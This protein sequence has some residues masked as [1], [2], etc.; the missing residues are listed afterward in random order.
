MIYLIQD[1]YKDDKGKYIDIL[2][3]GYSSKPFKESRENQ[4]KTHNYG[5]K[6]IGEREGDT[7]LEN[8]LHTK[9]KDLRLSEEWFLYS[10]DIVRE[11]FIVDEKNANVV[12][13]KE[14]YI[15][16]IQYYI[17]SNLTTPTEL[18]KHYIEKIIKELKEDDTILKYNEKDYDILPQIIRNVFELGYELAI[19]EIK[20][21]CS[22]QNDFFNDVPN[23]ISK[24]WLEENPWK[25]RAELFY[26]LNTRE[27]T[28][29]EFSR[30]LKKKMED[31]ETK[32]NAYN[33]LVNLKE[34]HLVAESYQ[35]YEKKRRYK[36]D[37]VAVNQ[38]MGSDIKPIFNRLVMI[39]EQRAFEIQQIDYADRFSMFNALEKQVDAEDMNEYIKT[40]YSFSLISEKYKYLCSLP[41]SIVLSI[42]SHLPSSV[43]SY[44]TVL[45]QNKIMA[46]RYNITDMKKEYEGIMGNQEIDIKGLIISVFTIG[47]EYTKSDV[48]KKLKEIYDSA[49]YTKT[50]KAVDL[51]EYFI[52]KSIQITNK[53][54]GKRDHGY[55]IINVKT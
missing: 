20:T 26:K 39:S 3:I 54:T 30:V 55:R 52:I 1:C 17:L 42:L 31:T 25:N 41:E 45:G 6:F 38:R 12:L 49:G 35:F 47:K 13:T 44:Y 18:G 19:E 5:Y 9:F 29:E 46:L 43:Q 53:D 48:K 10:D 14:Q 28:Q 50:P 51:G 7:T 22:I 34:K 24:E 2:K 15:S 27:K 36:E 37:Y 40:F 23:L 4:Y 21:S 8:Y 11:F 32:L 33:S 16:N